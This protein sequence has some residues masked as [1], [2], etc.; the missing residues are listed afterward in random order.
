MALIAAT[1]C[2]YGGWQ[3]YERFF[4]LTT[5]TLVYASPGSHDTGSERVA[6]I[7]LTADEA[8][9]GCNDVSPLRASERISG[10]TLEINIRGY[11]ATNESCA[12]QDLQAPTTYIPIDWKWLKPGQDKTVEITMAGKVS[13]FTMRLDGHVVA[14][15]SR[16]LNNVALSDG[17]HP[18][19]TDST[20][21]IDIYP[22]DVAQIYASGEFSD[23]D[24]LRP[25]LRKKAKEKGLVPADEKYPSIKQDSRQA[26]YVVVT[27]KEVPD[28]NDRSISLG[29]LKDRPKVEASL[30]RINYSDDYR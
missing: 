8:I 15:V 9:G 25:G 3:V 30:G 4:N 7:E 23:A 5:P 16:E 14:L 13:R 12:Q 28:R 18:D 24:D 2:I 26:L 10:D 11:T 6:T 20:R 29:N 19:D 22:Y 21:H 17:Y 27:S 1:L